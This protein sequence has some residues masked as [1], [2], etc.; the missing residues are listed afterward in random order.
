MDNQAIGSNPTF[1]SGEQAALRRITDAR[2]TG[3]A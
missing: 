1:T 3:R 2:F